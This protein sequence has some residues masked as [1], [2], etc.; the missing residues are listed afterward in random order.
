M[1]V[2]PIEL[3]LVEDSEPDVRLTIEASARR[4]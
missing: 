1:N 2:K 3:L 4:R